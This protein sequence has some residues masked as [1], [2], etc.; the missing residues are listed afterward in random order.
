MMVVNN[1][2]TPK[3]YDLTNNAID[4]ITISFRDADGE[5]ITI[6]SS[7][8]FGADLMKLTEI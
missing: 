3:N 4:N 2:Y 8:A 1:Y 7:Y 5:L 6:R